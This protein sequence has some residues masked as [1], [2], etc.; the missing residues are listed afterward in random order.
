LRNCE[1]IFDLGG[2]QKE[3]EELRKEMSQEGFWEH[4]KQGAKVNQRLK[5]LTGEIERWEGLSK[6]LTDLKELIALIA[7]D[8][9]S[10]DSMVS[11]VVL[12]TDRL[13]R[14]IRELEIE[15][16]FRDVEDE[17]GAILT[18]HPGAGGTESQDWSQMLSRMYLK[19]A[20]RRGF[21]TKILDVQ[22]GEEAGFKSF[23][24][25]VTGKFA[26]GY[27]K[28]EVGIH[29]LVRISPFDANSRR[30][31]SFASVH[32]YPEAKSEVEIVISEKELRVDT[33]RASGAGGQHVNKTDSAVRI[34]HLPTG[35]VA[36]SQS[37]R[38]QHRNRENAMKIL[39]ARLYQ[40]LKDEEEDRRGAL[41]K[42]KKD[43]SW[44]NQIRSYIFHPYNLIKDH[45]AGVESSNIQA[46]MDGEI[47]LFINANL[48]L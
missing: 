17:G 38:S 37:E 7:E 21:E 42:E 5:S 44:G 30:H 11:E 36:Q 35:L 45:R 41:D 10:G 14:A 26:Y 16:L 31:T 22:A 20:Q 47:D 27:L 48:K 15:S 19:W 1:V 18:I 12:E 8:D 6:S 4:H 25:E 2:K 9:E 43:I 3:L 13:S 32:I 23:T 46:V 40:Q 39:R 28:C 29:R 24:V 34:T 33:F